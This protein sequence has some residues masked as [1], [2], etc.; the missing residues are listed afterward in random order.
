MALTHKSLSK[1]FPSQFRL[2]GAIVY[3]QQSEVAFRLI[4]PLLCCGSMFGYIQWWGTASHYAEPSSPLSNMPCLSDFV[5]GEE[6]REP[7]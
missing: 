2:D 5:I 4:G 7:K 6:E 1:A 3:L